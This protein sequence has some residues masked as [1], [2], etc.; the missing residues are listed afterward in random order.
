MIYNDSEW[1]IIKKASPHY[2]SA[3][4]NY[5]RNVPSWLIEEITNV[6]ESATGKKILHKDFSCAICVFRIIQTIGK[7][8]FSD[9]EER[10]KLEEENKDG[11]KGNEKSKPR[12]SNAKKGNSRKS[13]RGNEQEQNMGM[14]NENL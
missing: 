3:K 10:N 11:E 4:R 7:T 12:N 1:L 5:I 2:E 8:Y 14:D 9:L 13:K 6:Y